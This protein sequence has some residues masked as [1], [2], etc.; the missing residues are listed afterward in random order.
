MFQFSV[1]TELFWHVLRIV[2]SCL[3]NVLQHIMQAVVAV[4][5]PA[6]VAGQ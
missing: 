1:V 6:A 5:R 4:N 3:P 2:L